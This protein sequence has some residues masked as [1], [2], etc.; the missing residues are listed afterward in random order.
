MKAHTRKV[1]P[2]GL[3]I[4]S[5]LFF[6]NPN[7][8]VV[9]VLP[10]LIGYILLITGL[11]CLGDLNE[12]IGEA[13]IRLMK[14]LI[15]EVAKG[16]T[17][18]AI[19][20]GLVTPQ[21]ESTFTLLATLVFGVIEL[22]ILVP[23]VRMLFAGMLQLATKHGSEA[24]FATRPKKLPREPRRGLRTPAQK[25]AFDKRV[26]RV[27]YR[28][29]TLPCALEKLQRLTMVFLFAKPL[30]ALLPEFS[31]L[32]G[33]EYNEALVNYYGF[34]TLFRAVAVIAL[35]PL[36]LYWLVRTIRFALA[37]RRDTAFTAACEQQYVHEILP[38][39]AM[40]TQR[41]VKLALSVLGIGI[42]LS[43]DFYLEYYNVIPDVLSAA[44]LIAGAWLLRKY[45]TNTKPVIFAA[46]F[47]AVLTLVSDA[48]NA[49][50]N[51][52]YY[53]NAIYKDDAAAM[54]FYATCAVTVLENI[55]FLVTL[56]LLVFAMKQMIVKYCGFSVTSPD[57]PRSSERV[58]RVHRSLF[59]TLYVFL[60][61]AVACATTAVLYDFLKPHVP[62]WWMIDFAVSIVFICLFY[63]SSWRIR[64]QVEY[65][66][67][68][69]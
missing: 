10:D 51:I 27:T 26:A 47:Y 59:D 22:L 28:N 15:V 64:E 44:F 5:L 36:A 2:W 1:F 56:L 32:S 54:S 16:A 20:G 30:M 63:R 6:W 34:I 37:L 40:F 21:E 62:F 14:M 12:S 42:I 43:I 33:T 4:A 35:L 53:F 41:N 60:G 9:D 48:L 58:R 7:I 19:F 52:V 50:F 3:M 11:Y 68:L 46:A 31:A 45:V 13:R 61:G 23:A 65:K 69:S 17:F 67:M 66:Y 49:H 8:Q 57:D 55:M 24:V 29:R 18:V 38:N 25:K 39:T